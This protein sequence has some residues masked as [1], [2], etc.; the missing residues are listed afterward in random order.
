VIFPF[1]SRCRSFFLLPLNLR[2]GLIEL[3]SSILMSSDSKRPLAPAPPGVTTANDS[4]Q[5]RKNVG[6]ACL[7]CKARKLKVPT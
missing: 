2:H 6:T 5:R 3:T 7:A 1:L 4:H